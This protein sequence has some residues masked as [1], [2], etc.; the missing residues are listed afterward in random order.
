MG[1]T[2]GDCGDTVHFRTFAGC[3]LSGTPR[4]EKSSMKVF[5]VSEL[6]S[7]HEKLK[8]VKQVAYGQGMSKLDPG[9]TSQQGV[10]LGFT[11]WSMIPLA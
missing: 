9:F 11:C 1:R 7:L 5:L 6:N 8:E 3:W 2:E 10:W 4:S